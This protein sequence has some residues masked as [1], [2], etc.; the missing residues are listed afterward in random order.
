[1][2]AGFLFIQMCLLAVV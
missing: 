1:M 2:T